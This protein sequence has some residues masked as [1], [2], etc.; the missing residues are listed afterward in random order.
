M[1]GEVYLYV[2]LIGHPN[3]FHLPNSDIDTASSS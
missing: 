1:L 3:S 2:F